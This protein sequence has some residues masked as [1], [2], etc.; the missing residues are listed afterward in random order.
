MAD[1]LDYGLLSPRGKSST[2]CSPYCSLGMRWKESRTGCPTFL[3]KFIVIGENDVNQEIKATLKTRD[4]SKFVILNNGVTIICKELRNIVRNQF[5]L[6]DYQ[7]VNGCQT[8]HVLYHSRQELNDRV[9]ITL[10]IISTTDEET[11]NKIIKATNRQTEVTDEQMLS[12]TDFHKKLED[13]YKTF[14]GTK[15]L[16]YERRSKQYATASD[17]EKVRIVTLPLQLKSFASMFMD[18]PHISSRYFGRLI[19]DA[20]GVFQ[21][22]HKLLPYYTSAFALYKLEYLFRN[23]QFDL[24]YRKYRYHILMIMK[25]RC[26]NGKNTPPLNSNDIEKLCESINEVM[27]DHQRFSSLV[28]ECLQVL[29]KAVMDMTNTDNP[30]QIAI[31]EDLK[32]IAQVIDE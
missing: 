8:S 9:F 11:V 27:Y 22:N 12:L 21:E 15:K 31:V 4:S 7:I 18:K 26:L 13:F 2:S 24:K 14:N 20:E 28:A 5:Q 6:S 17:I 10:K 1:S 32:S 25:Y 19:K 3:S 29:D 16:Y 30:R 23:K